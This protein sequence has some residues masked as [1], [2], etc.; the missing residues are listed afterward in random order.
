MAL[1]KAIT[2]HS[3]RKINTST[4]RNISHKKNWNQ[5]T[6]EVHVEPSPIP[7]IKSRNYK[8]SD[9]YCVEIKLHQDLTSQKLDLY[10]FKMALFD[11]G[12]AKEFFF[13]W[14]GLREPISCS[15]LG[16]VIPTHNRG[17]KV[18]RLCPSL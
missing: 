12:K 15:L 8:I 11:K 6:V 10:E 18:T 3:Q 7:P 4:M 14:A 9:K 5:K 16:S 1:S 17:Y 13:L 2:P